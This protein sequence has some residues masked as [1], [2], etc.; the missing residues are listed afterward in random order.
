[1][2]VGADADPR[3]LAHRTILAAACSARLC[4]AATMGW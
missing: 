3:K 4:A 2:H 1:V